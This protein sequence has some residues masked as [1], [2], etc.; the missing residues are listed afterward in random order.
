[1]SK[2]TGFSQSKDKIL[3]EMRIYRNEIFARHGMKFKSEDLN[4][5][6]SAMEWYESKDNF[7]INQ[8]SE[9]EILAAETIKLFENKYPEFTNNDK[10]TVVEIFEFIK[11]FTYKNIEIINST[12]D[13]YDN[14]L[15]KDTIHTT[16]I[17]KKFNEFILE[18]SFSKENKKIWFETHKNPYLR[19][20]DHEILD[21]YENYFIKGY[22]ATKYTIARSMEMFNLPLKEYQI[23]IGLSSI[24]REGLTIEK[25]EYEEYLNNFNDNLL[26][27]PYDESGGGLYIWFEPLNKFIDFYHP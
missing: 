19:I 6:F 15:G 20:G 13:N 1:M 26:L 18:Y 25:N 27:L 3:S 16:V 22:M 8:L 4:K 23:N 12:I 2:I 7:N 24:R 10:E 21:N 17:E 5:Y 11:K 14:L 9:K